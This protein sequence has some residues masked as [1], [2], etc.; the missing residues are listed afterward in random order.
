MPA[1][2]AVV[3]Y[4]APA[5]LS[6]TPGPGELPAQAILG[7]DATA[8][9]VAAASPAS[10]VSGRFPPAVLVHGTADRLI[11]PA[12]SVRFYDALT[13]AGVT[14]EL[15]LIAGQDHEFDM[16]PRY[17]RITSDLVAGF[18]RAQVVEPEQAAKEVLEG[19]PLASM[20]PPGPGGPAAPPAAGG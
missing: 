2:A 14:A 3:A 15:H 13:A 12:V 9:E 11:P 18:L 20:P 4:Y 19:N 17:T 16:T 5:A 1:L 7:P 8:G 10:Y 6:L